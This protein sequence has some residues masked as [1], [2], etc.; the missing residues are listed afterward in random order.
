MKNIILICL[1]FF[2][3]NISAANNQWRLYL[4]RPNE[5]P[6][7]IN[8]FSYE[9]KKVSFCKKAVGFSVS[10]TAENKGLYWYY[11]AEA[12]SLTGDKK[13]YL[14]LSRL[15][16]NAQTPYAFFGEVTK[17][18]IY[19]QSPHEPADHYF[20]DLLVNAL[21]VVAL[22]NSEGFEVAL[23]NTPAVFNNYTNQTFDLEHREVTLSSGDNGNI[24]IEGS[25]VQN[26]D[27]IDRRKKGLYRIEPYYFPV[28]TKKTHRFDGIYLQTKGTD[29]GKLR[30]SINS[31]ISQHWSKGTVVDLLGATFF[32]T[33]YM[34]LRVNETG[35]SK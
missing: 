1:V 22:K 34:N 11:V 9:G 19:R 29:L 27:T 21:P 8:T 26:T 20:K 31:I 18:G 3:L 17:P 14:S 6:I 32:S 23:S 28:N 16:D 12:K 10:F 24:F 33:A 13:C 7:L 25:F 4:E 30:E 15:Y 35:R 2:T 5:K